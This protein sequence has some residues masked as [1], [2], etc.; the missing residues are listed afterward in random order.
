MGIY[1]LDGTGLKFILMGCVNFLAKLKTEIDALNVFPVPDGDT[2]TNMY[3]TL[4]EGTKAA[5]R[6]DG[7]DLDKVIKAAANGCLMG[8]RGNSGVILSQVVRGFANALSGKTKADAKDLAKAIEEG[9]KLSYQAVSEP[10]EG[11]I[12]TVLRKSAEA[13]HHAAERSPELTRFMVAV[14]RQARKALEA[15]PDQLPV[16]KEAGVVD[17]GGKGWVVILQGILYTLRKVEQ[18]GL[19]DDFTASQKKRLAEYIPKELESDITYTYCTEFLL[20]GNGLPLEQIKRELQPYGDCL[21]VVG[22]EQVTKVHIHSNHP[23][24]VIE[25]C[26]NYGSLHKLRISNMQEQNEN[27]RQEQTAKPLAVIAVALGE[28]I[29]NIMESIG[30]DIVITGGQTMNPSTED[31]LQAVEEVPSKN[32]IIMPNNKN[33]IMAARQA[34]SMTK[35]SVAVIPTVSIPQGLS[36]LLVYN[37]EGSLEEN[38]ER[39]NEAMEMVRTGEIT[40][41]VRDVSIGGRSVSS[42]DVIGLVDGRLVSSGDDIYSVMKQLVQELTSDG[43][44]LVTLY[45][46]QDLTGEI[47]QQ[48]ADKLREDF[49]DLEIE[50]HYGGQPLYHYIISA[51]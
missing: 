26:L 8:A 40:K 32:V 11:T 17:A 5:Q 31:I 18:I 34:A 3:L 36:A 14:S 39:M 46:G 9:A 7:N 24:L 4:L 29:V 38:E 44:E 22:S 43:E 41:A 13:A 20:K 35:K 15:T 6:V 37:P 42:G 23:G 25:T 45:Y 50:V 47:A 33:I 28:G 1:N 49:L 16:L 2:G 12:L 21:M 10:V 48:A 51:E 27:W 19:L 30:A